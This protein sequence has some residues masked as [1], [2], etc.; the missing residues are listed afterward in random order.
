[1]ENAQPVQFVGEI[2]TP[3]EKIITASPQ[4]NLAD[5]VITLNQKGLRGL[6]VVDDSD[7]LLGMFSE[8]QMLSDPSYVH[9]RT[10]LKL[11]SEMKYYKKD[12][13]LIRDQ[14]NGI[15]DATMQQV[16]NEHPKV[17]HPKDLIFDARQDFYKRENNPMAVV[18]ENH[19]L[20]GIL[21]LSDM[22]RFYD[23]PLQSMVEETDVY[24]KVDEF[25]EQFEK[26]FI[27]VSRFRASAWLVTSILFSLIGFAISFLFILRL[28]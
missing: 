26:Q 1:L 3:R 20:V 27:I 24:R 19:R 18:D 25:V 14:L 2:M 6:P 8:R 7:Q 22:A 28:V 16:M 12:H 13:S 15:V 21:A 11:F 17:L 23:I 9:L 5:A 4:T 10:L